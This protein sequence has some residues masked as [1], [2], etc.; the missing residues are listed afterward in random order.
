MPELATSRVAAA[1]RQSDVTVA[2]VIGSNV[3]NLLGILSVTALSAPRSSTS[4]CSAEGAGSIGGRG[5]P[6]SANVL[7]LGTLTH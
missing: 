7:C 6:V 4:R 5:V 1:R 3:F 2:S